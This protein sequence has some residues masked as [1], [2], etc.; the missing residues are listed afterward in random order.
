MSITASGRFRPAWPSPVVI[1]PF[2][3]VRVLLFEVYIA[4]R[5]AILEYPD[6][7]SPRE[8]VIFGQSSTFQYRPQLAEP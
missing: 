6:R 7:H 8:D 5:D 4:G 3:H 1:A 2:R